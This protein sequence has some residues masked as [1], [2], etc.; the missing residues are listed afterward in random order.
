MNLRAVLKALKF[1]I[2]VPPQLKDNGA[3]AGNTYFDTLGLSGLLVLLVPGTVDAAIGSTLSTTVPSLEECN[4]TDGTYTAITG[5]ALATVIGAGE[6]NTLHGIAVDLTKTHKRYIEITAPT[7]GDGT[8]GVNFAAIAIGFP[9]DQMPYSAAGMG[10]DELI[11][12]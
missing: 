5:A 1:G 10:L 12:A 2:L 7:A 9:S 11:E 3:F 8:T 4:T 6:D